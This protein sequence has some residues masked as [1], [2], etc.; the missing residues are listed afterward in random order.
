MKKKCP[1][2]NIKY[3]PC[4]PRKM[5]KSFSS[6]Y[7]YFQIESKNKKRYIN[8]YSGIKSISNYKYMNSNFISLSKEA[9]IFTSKNEYIKNKRI[10]LFNNDNQFDNNN[11]KAFFEQ[12]YKTNLFRNNNHIFYKTTIFRGGKYCCFIKY[13]IIISK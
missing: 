8:L 7:N 4:S 3:E 13:M 10:Q 12:G 9:N 2:I 11:K 1:Q 5:K 6:T